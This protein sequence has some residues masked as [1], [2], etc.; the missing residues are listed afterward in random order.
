MVDDFLDEE[1]SDVLFLKISGKYE[2]AA[3]RYLDIFNRTIDA[4]KK[5]Y[6]FTELGECY[7]F[8]G[9]KGQADFSKLCLRTK[10]RKTDEL[11]ALSLEL[12]NYWNITNGDYEK[13]INNLIELKNNFTKDDLYQ[14]ISLFTLGQIYY[15]HVNDVKTAERYFDELEKLYPNDQ[16]VYD[17][18]LLMGK[19]VENFIIREKQLEKDDRTEDTEELPSNFKLLGN[20]P[21]PFNPS[22]I[23]KFALPVTSNVKLTIYNMMGQEIKTLTRDNLSAGTH[24]FTW[25]GT[26][27]NSELVSSGIY[28]YRLEAIGNDGRSFSK[29]AKMTML[30]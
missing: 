6:I 1:L 18:K 13:V 8:L 2:E 11:Y 23:I 19:K 5:K 30:K 28:I 21:N 17:S 15:I 25:N 12:E 4:K 10:E 29:S 9:T 16:L 22:T 7:R 26:N 3:N 24:N 20:Y 14:R 27:K